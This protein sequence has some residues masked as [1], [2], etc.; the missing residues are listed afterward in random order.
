MQP[1]ACGHTGHTGGSALP[2]QQD[3]WRGTELFI[4]LLVT[5]SPVLFI[6][7]VRGTEDYLRTM[8]IDKCSKQA[9]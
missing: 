9:E 6:H 3:A 2:G 8:H 5:L 4:C 7:M 1:Q